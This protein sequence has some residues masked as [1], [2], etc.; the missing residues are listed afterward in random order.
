MR[1]AV[2][3]ALLLLGAA[4]ARA[5]DPPAAEDPRAAIAER[6]MVFKVSKRHHLVIVPPKQRDPKLKYPGWTVLAE[7]DVYLTDGKTID[8]Q[9]LQRCKT[10]PEESNADTSGCS[11]FARHQISY[12]PSLRAD[13]ALTHFC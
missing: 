7:A 1:R 12:P 8:R 9:V 13:T 6:G 11:G 4:V 3:A 2:V 10:S 5:D